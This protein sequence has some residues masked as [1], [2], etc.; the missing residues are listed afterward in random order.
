MINE[1]SGEGGRG[2]GGSAERA[3]GRVRGRR[4]DA[5]IVPTQHGG[6]ENFI[7][8]FSPRCCQHAEGCWRCAAKDRS[9]EAQDT[10]PGS[11]HGEPRHAFSPL[12]SPCLN[13]PLPGES[14][15]GMRAP[16]RFPSLPLAFLL[17]P[18]RKPHAGAAAVRHVVRERSPS[19]AVTYGR[20][21][22]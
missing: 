20:Y 13:S 21:S 14:W 3:G 9:Q 17:K 19:R 18:D 10:S 8:P 15:E 7:F 1:W 6:C 12:C 5:I 16:A 4:R 22:S 11:P 2:A